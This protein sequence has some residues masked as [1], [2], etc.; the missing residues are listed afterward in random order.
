MPKQEL[1]SVRTPTIIILAAYCAIVLSKN[2]RKMKLMMAMNTRMRPLI[3]R[4]MVKMKVMTA[5]V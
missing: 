5:R 2:K 1:S 3:L 4:P